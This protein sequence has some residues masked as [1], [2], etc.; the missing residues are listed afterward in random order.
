MLQGGAYRAAVLAH[1][2]SVHASLKPEQR[3]RSASSLQRSVSG[4][5]ALHEGDENGE[6]DAKDTNECASTLAQ[7]RTAYN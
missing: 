7:Q 5:H 1:K 3:Q 2:A 4:L 6:G